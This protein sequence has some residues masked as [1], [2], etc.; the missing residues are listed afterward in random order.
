LI[1]DEDTGLYGGG[2]GR[3]L[4]LSLGL[5]SQYNVLVGLDDLK[6]ISSATYNGSFKLFKVVVVVVV[7]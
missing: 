4:K 6:L 1:I 2:S 3:T 7:V 5:F